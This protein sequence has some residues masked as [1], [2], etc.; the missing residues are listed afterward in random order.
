[1]IDKKEYICS[2]PFNYTE[3]FD[4]RQYLC[5]PSWLPVD[6]WD[7]KSIKSSF[8]S[9]K[10]KE[11]WLRE[12]YKDGELEAVKASLEDI[13]DNPASDTLLAFAEDFYARKYHKK[14]TSTVTDML[15]S[16]S[17]TL[18]I[19]VSQNQQVERGVLAHYAREGITGWRT[20]NRLWRSW[21]PFVLERNK[22]IF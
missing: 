21:K 7:G 12:S 14:R 5:C 11:K 15:R 4:D 20:E 9:D 16:A 19:D 2:A 8:Q 3:V 10:A 17:R 6:V 18:D 22:K 1:M 13:I